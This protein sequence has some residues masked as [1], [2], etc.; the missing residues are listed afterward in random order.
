MDRYLHKV[1]LPTWIK[2]DS[3]N[4]QPQCLHNSGR[5]VLSLVNKCHIWA[6]NMDSKALDRV[7]LCHSLVQHPSKQWVDQECHRRALSRLNQDYHHNR[8]WEDH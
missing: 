1:K 6:N 2:A 4:L 3:S 5:Q 8:K 7:R